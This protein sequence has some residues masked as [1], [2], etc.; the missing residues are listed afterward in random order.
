MTRPAAWLG[1]LLLFLVA[2][3]LAYLHVQLAWLAEFAL[4]E[5][6]YA[7]GG[8]LAGR[9]GTIYVDFFEHHFPLLHQLLGLLWHI[10]D[11]DPTHI[12]TLR[13]LFLPV[14]GLVVIAGCLAN[15][16]DDLANAAAWWTAPV[17][18]SAPT[19]SAMGT[20]LR[21]DVLA[22][23]LFFSCLALLRS[24]S[25]QSGRRRA[26][27]AALAG[28][29]AVVA[30]WSTLKVAIYAG[31][32]F[33]AALVADLIRR[34]NTTESDETPSYF[35]GHPIAFVAGSGTA[36]A[37][38][39]LGLALSGSVG[40]WWRWAVEFSFA[41]QEVYPGF[42][43]TRNFFQLL[44]HSAWLLPLAVVGIVAT[45]RRRPRAAD[46]D[47]LLLAAVPSTAASYVWQTAP[48]LYSLIPLTAVL[49]L[50][51]ARGLAWCWQ[52]A[53]RGGSSNRT[54]AALLFLLLAAGE[55]HRT[56]DALRRLRQPGNASQLQTLTQLGRMTLPDDAVFSP[57]AMQ[58]ARPSAHFFY[59]L[60]AAT[61]RLEAARLNR[62][63]VPA[64]R[65]RGVTVYYHHPLSER[66]PAAAWAYLRTHFLPY[67]QDLWIY[68]RRYPTIDGRASG[69]FFAVQEGTYF[70]SPP[71]ALGGEQSLHIGG[72]ALQTPIVALAAGRHRIE[73][74]GGVPEVSIVW[75]P[76]DGQPFRP[77]PELIPASQ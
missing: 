14:F 1:K 15:R 37:L 8:W 64:L 26:V 70:V 52:W 67:D 43:W 17:L 24:A 10:L 32:P 34:H 65:E 53:T 76:R 23:A 61:K 51:A 62:E 41:H 77:R 35:L 42:S 5:F 30:L 50:F 48:Y 38:I 36:A 6:Q 74:R 72:T 46:V 60:E 20:Q 56:V 16:S 7:H 57:W 71:E 45:L 13:M 11:D 2:A 40:A 21:P 4:D 33:L 66:L 9:G 27:L 44:D 55:L 3:G 29:V 63:L 54:F 39:G 75:M 68:G 28:V 22:L 19:L 12:L 47:W 59:F 73:Y 58:V 25:T 69:D 31:T 18:L 49:G